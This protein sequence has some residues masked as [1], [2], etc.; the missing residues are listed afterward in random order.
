MIFE[1]R[2]TDYG[3]YE[4]RKSSSRRHVLAFIIVVLLAVLVS[5]LPLIITE[6]QKLRPAPE[7]IS[8]DTTLAELALQ[9]E[10]E[11][12]NQLLQD[13]TP[14]P[15]PLKSTIQFV[16]PVIVDDDEIDP[17]EQLK[18]QVELQQS[19]KQISLFNVEGT[20]DEAGID[21]AE[22]E[23]HRQAAED[24]DNKVYDFV[25]Q[26]PEFPGGQAELMKY[27]NNNINYPQIAIENN[28]QGRVTVRFTVGKDGSVTNIVV[29]QGPDESLN[30]EA[31]RLVRSMPKW[32]PG[33]YNGRT[34]NVNYNL[35]VVFKLN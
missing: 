5:F 18:S 1:G 4:M 30:Q 20:D 31:V 23:E 6:V 13:A 33:K 7:N 9:E 25:Q 11:Q 8:A 32:I 19:D 14:P 35:P 3:A 29:L 12:Q 2:P 26:M 34:V 28:I 17:D 15:P 22:L 27:L 24:L 21:K 16:A 10:I